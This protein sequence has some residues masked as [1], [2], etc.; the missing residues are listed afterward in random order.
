MGSNLH[1]TS[2]IV[3]DVYLKHRILTRNK[4]AK[5]C[6][7]LSIKALKTILISYEMWILFWLNH[8]GEEHVLFVCVFL[9]V[10]STVLSCKTHPLSDWGCH[11]PPDHYWSPLSEDCNK[12]TDGWDL[13]LLT[14]AHC[15]NLPNTPE[16]WH[17]NTVS[18]YLK[19][20]KSNRTIKYKVVT[21]EQAI[22]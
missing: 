13:Q 6:G 1:W 5:W 14:L 2:C 4:N 21:V 9:S 20:L 7:V 22:L 3:G 17:G 19:T 11:L 8:A 12:E 15:N 16:N 18:H 10:L